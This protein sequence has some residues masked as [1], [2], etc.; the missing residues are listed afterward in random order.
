MTSLSEIRLRL[1]RLAK[2]QPA[3]TIGPDQ[4]GNAV[5]IAAAA[6]PL[7]IGAAGL[8]VDG[9]EWVLQKRQIQ[10]AADGAAIAGVYGLIGSQDL[11]SAVNDSIVRAGGVAAN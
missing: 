7:L 5:M 11:D 2:L 6:F 10:S 4:R 9:I 1:A 3:R 8:A